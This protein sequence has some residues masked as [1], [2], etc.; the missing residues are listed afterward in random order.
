MPLLLHASNDDA[1]IRRHMSTMFSPCDDAHGQLASFLSLPSAAFAAW[2]SRFICHGRESI[3]HID[4]FV[5]QLINVVSRSRFFAL[6]TIYFGNNVC[7]SLACRELADFCS[8]TPPFNMQAPTISCSHSEFISPSKG[9]CASGL[10]GALLSRTPGEGPQ[11]TRKRI[12]C[13]RTLQLISPQEKSRIGTRYENAYV[14]SFDIVY[15]HTYNHSSLRVL[16]LKSCPAACC[17][18]RHVHHRQPKR[19]D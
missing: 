5:S 3:V 18:H 4:N 17:E 15:I 1:P 12:S 13:G 19:G 2:F 10:L 9:C 8:G 14:N 7:R 16:Y 11:Q 6:S